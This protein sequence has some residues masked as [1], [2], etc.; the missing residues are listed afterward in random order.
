MA[1]SFTT[2]AFL[3]GFK[4]GMVAGGALAVVG[5]LAGAAL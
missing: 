4:L 1:V 3:H 5:F 2:L